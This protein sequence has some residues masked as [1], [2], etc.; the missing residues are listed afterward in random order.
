MACLLAW[1]GDAVGL[2]I[3]LALIPLATT[4]LGPAVQRVKGA[5]P[6]Q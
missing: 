2:V 4:V 5:W 3:G 6:A 1:L